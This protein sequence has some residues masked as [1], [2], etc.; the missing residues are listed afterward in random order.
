MIELRKLGGADWGHPSPLS[1]PRKKAVD[2]YA[3]PSG[4]GKQRSWAL[5][6]ESVS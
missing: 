6:D 2:N 5:I 4:E 3:N 1:G